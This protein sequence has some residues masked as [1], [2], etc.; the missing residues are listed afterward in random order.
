MMDL[1]GASSLKFVK[2]GVTLSM[3]AHFTWVCTLN[4]PMVP[5]QW[6]R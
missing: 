1:G 2:D 4:V 5:P 6:T 3:N